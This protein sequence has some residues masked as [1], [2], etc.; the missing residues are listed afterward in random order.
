MHAIIAFWLDS[1]GLGPPKI[2]KKRKNALGK[3]LFFGLQKSMYKISFSMILESFLGSF[4]SSG[5]TQ[6]R[7]INFQLSFGAW[8]PPLDRFGTTFGII[9]VPFWGYFCGGF[10]SFSL[11]FPSLGLRWGSISICWDSFGSPCF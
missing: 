3:S 8:S 11:M 7:G 9:L 1:Q 10:G 2:V 4:L 5:A 6:N